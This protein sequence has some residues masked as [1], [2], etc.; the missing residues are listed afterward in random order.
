MNQKLKKKIILNIPYVAIGPVSYTHL[1]VYKRQVYAYMNDGS[2]RKFDVKPLIK[3]GGVFKKIE[4]KEIF[5]NTLTVLNGTVAWDIAGNRNRYKCIDID[6]MTI[7][8]SPVV[9]DFP[10]I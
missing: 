10:E 1:D 4:D 9:P 3:K 5:K 8:K 7:F 2:V 6:P